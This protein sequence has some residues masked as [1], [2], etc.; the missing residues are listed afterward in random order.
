[1][2]PTNVNKTIQAIE[3][4]SNA[5]DSTLTSDN[6]NKTINAISDFDKSMHK[7]ED[8]LQK[9]GEIFGK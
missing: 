6:V 5:M 8:R 3:K 7:A 9:I 2:H 1:M 4:I